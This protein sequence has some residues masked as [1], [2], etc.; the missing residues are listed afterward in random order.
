MNISNYIKLKTFSADR[1]EKRKFF[2]K[3]INSLTLYHYKKSKV[4]FIDKVITWMYVSYLYY[5]LNYHWSI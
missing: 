5:Y 2:E 4:D 3:S 1:K